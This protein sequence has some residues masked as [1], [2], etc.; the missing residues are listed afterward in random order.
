MRKTLTVLISED[1]HLKLK[2][3]CAKNQTSMSK[4]IEEF[5][6][7]IGGKQNE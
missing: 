1:K 7:T 2:I 5:I 4:V 6:R 3:H